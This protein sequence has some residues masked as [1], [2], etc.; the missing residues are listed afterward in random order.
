MLTLLDS[1][2]D[3]V[4]VT[5][6]ESP[7]STGFGEADSDTVGTEK[8]SSRIVIRT[9]L[10]GARRHARRQGCSPSATVNVSSASSASCAVV[11]VPVPVVA[12]EAMVMLVSVPWS[13]GS[14]ESSVSVTGITTWLD[15]AR[16]SL[17]VTVTLEPSLTGFGEADSD[18]AGG[19]PP[20]P[21]A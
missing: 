9:E 16:D 8:S 3:S 1:A 21:A 4:A 19:G 17:A 13:V 20:A 12:P 5:V 11:M 10:G 15:S 14:A 2:E 6:T 18:T 7:S